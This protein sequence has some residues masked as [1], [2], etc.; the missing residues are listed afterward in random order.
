MLTIC[1]CS[2]ETEEPITEDIGDV[3]ETG[4]KDLTTTEDSGRGSIDQSE[5][6][7]KLETTADDEGAIKPEHEADTSELHSEEEIMASDKIIV[8]EKIVEQSVSAGTHGESDAALLEDSVPSEEQQVSGLE[9]AENSSAMKTMSTSGM[10]S[11][12]KPTF[13]VEIKEASSSDDSMVEP[14]DAV[15]VQK[16]VRDDLH[17][18]TVTYST[19]EIRKGV[20]GEKPSEEIDRLS[21]ENTVREAQT[22]HKIISVDDESSMLLPVAKSD[23]SSSISSSFIVLEEYWEH[24]PGIGPIIPELQISA[25]VEYMH[26]W[27]AKQQGM[28]MPRN[29]NHILCPPLDLPSTV[30]STLDNVSQY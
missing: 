6:P 23:K 29:I 10:E 4:E 24:V 20:F 26:Y 30:N 8:N 12:T 19:G 22:V 16:F 15:T 13:S 2:S 7:G 21:S 18:S 9:S 27:A 1:F 17:G 3:S 11:D 5:K 25:V 14:H 28:V